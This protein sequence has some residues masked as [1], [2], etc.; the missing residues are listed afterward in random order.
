MPRTIE[1][2][3]ELIGTDTIAYAL[4]EGYVNPED[5]ADPLHQLAAR[6]ARDGLNL[7]GV[8]LEDYLP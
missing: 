3:A 6:N 8:V 4:Q 2:I 1:E 5:F 7:L